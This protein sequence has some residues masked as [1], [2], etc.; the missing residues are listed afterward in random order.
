MF[1]RRK[2]AGA[3]FNLDNYVPKSISRKGHLDRPLLDDFGSSPQAQLWEPLS[4]KFDS[5]LVIDGQVE[6]P[7]TRNGQGHGFAIVDSGSVLDEE[8]LFCRTNQVEHLYGAGVNQR[9]DVDWN[10]FPCGWVAEFLCFV[11][12]RRA[13]REPP[14]HA[15]GHRFDLVSG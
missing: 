3:G 15:G 12:N 7:A 4:S 8:I 2:I 11:A 10:H 6:L 1:P 14:A 9:G 13:D 5:R